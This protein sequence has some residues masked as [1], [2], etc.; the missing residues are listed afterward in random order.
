M[1]CT[2]LV[3]IVDLVISVMFAYIVVMCVRGGNLSSLFLPLVL[4]VLGANSLYWIIKLSI[5]R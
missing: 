4:T 1:K 3:R 2:L 5:N